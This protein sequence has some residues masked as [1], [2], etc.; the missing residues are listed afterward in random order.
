MKTAVLVF[1]GSNCD[2]DCYHAVKHVMGREADFIWHQERSLKGYGLVIVP[3]GFSYGDYLRPGAIARFSPVMAA[4]DDFASRGGYVMGIC[5]GFQILTEARLLPGALV[6]NDTLKFICE[7]VNLRVE[8]SNSFL[9]SGSAR[10]DVLRL[11]IA[12]MEGCYIAG[13]DTLK[14]LD[15]EDRVLFRY[16]DAS[17]NVTRE[18]NPNGAARNIAGV[19][20]EKRNVAGMMPH[21]ERVME[22]PLGGQDGLALFTSALNALM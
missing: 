16:C 4:L 19:L 3:G 14:A 9:T 6:R 21:P 7:T 20:S 2:H 8:T 13:E 18:S 5:N 11:P 15:D 22:N 17:G 10:G 12:H 1:P